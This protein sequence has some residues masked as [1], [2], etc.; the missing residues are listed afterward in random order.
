MKQHV[1]NI[2]T[3]WADLDMLGHVNNVVYMTYFETARVEALLSSGGFDREGGT[4]VV[5]V[6]ANISYR[7]SATHPSKL[8]V[9]TTVK[10]LGNTSLVLNHVLADRDGDRVYC[11][12]DVTCVC[13]NLKE[14]KPVP[15][16]GF[17]R[18]WAGVEPS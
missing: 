16:P 12:A 7:D 9:V 8:K 17:I 11:E 3:R 18:E 5:V 6:Q 10:S 15:V 13:I 4:G 14:G 2:D 1:C